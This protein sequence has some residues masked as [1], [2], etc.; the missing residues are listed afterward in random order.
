MLEYFNITLINLTYDPNKNFN[1]NM[2]IKILSP[3]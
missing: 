2:Y 3:P 1:F